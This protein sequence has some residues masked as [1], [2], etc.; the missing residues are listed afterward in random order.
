MSIKRWLL[1]LV[2]EAKKETRRE[3]LIKQVLRMSKQTVKG[4]SE[5]ARISRKTGELADL[6]LPRVMAKSGESGL[7]W[8]DQ[9]AKEWT[10]AM[11]RAIGKLLG[12]C[13]RRESLE[14]AGA[15]IGRQVT[16]LAIKACKEIDESLGIASE[17][18]PAASGNT[19]DV[20]MKL[21][22]DLETQAMLESDPGAKAAL[23][24][25]AERIRKELTQEK[26]AA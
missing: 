20:R 22:E 7:P 12:M 9:E 25:H 14:E 18:T 3:A 8:D 21:V 5:K 23:Q 17:T 6:I 1:R 10:F 24:A 15:D 26:G 4:D 13:L 19:A 2:G 11:I 16:Q